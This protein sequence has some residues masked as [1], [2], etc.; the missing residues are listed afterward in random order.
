MYYDTSTRI[1]NCQL[2]EQWF[3]LHKD[4]L[5]YE[6]QIT[7]INDNNPFVA[8][9]SSEVV[10]EY[11]N[12]LGYLVTLKNVSAKTSCA[13]D[14][15]STV[16][17]IAEYQGYLDGE[18][19]MEEEGDVLKSHALKATKVTKPSAPTTSKVTKP[20]GDKPLKPKSTSAQPP[21][22]KPAST[23][24]SKIVPKKKLKLIKVTPNEPSPPKRSKVGLV[25]KRY[26]P[27]SLLKLVDEFAD[28]GVPIAEPRLD[29][30]KADL[31]RGIKL[32]L[33]DLEERNQGPAC[34]VVFRKP[35]SKRFQPLPG[36]LKKKSLVDQ[37]IF[38][39]RSPTTIGPSGNAESPS[40]D[41]ELADS[42][43]K[44]DKTMT[45]VNKEKD[46]S[47]KISLRSR[48]EF[49]MKVKLD[50]TLVNKMK[51]RLDQTLE[52]L[53]LPTKEQVILEDPANSI[54]TLSSLQNL[55]KELRFTNQF[56]MDKTHEREPE[57]TNA[58]SEVQSMVTVPIHQDTSSVPP[59]TTSVLDLTTS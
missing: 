50:Q 14:S 38:Q 29:N 8:P 26:K 19:G 46:A 6:L 4:I 57:K 48:L 13:S 47:N 40:S 52:N 30:E 28:E 23:K 22:P 1:Y 27:K 7:P 56:F 45:P 24:P 44:S 54:G 39:R 49:N 12:T 18:H 32:I 16:L 58:E 42:E 31:Q 3:K 2:D 20:T 41:A 43:T 17:H 53:K 34:P 55:K 51:T 5:R 9:P 35:D 37:Y 33:K 15:L 11:V 10:I 59:M 36:T 21:K 25:G